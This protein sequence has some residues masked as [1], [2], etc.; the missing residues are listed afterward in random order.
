MAKD[1][2]TG[3]ILINEEVR[4]NYFLMRV[5]LPAI[6]PEPLPGNFVMVRIAGL[7]EPFLGRPL[8][9]YAFGRNKSSCSLEILY[10]VCGKGTQI[11]ARLIEGSQLEVHGPLGGSFPIFPEKK[12][13]V[14][15]AGGIG[16]APLSMLAQYLCKNTSF[17][18]S[19]MKFYLGAQSVDAMVGREKLGKLCYDINVCTD[20]GTL[21]QKAQVVAAFAGD[22]KKYK[23]ADTVIYACGPRGMLKALAGMLEGTEFI[24][25][26]SL[27]EKMACGTGACMG[28][29]VA[30][31]DAAGAPLYKRVCA[32]G[33][34][35]NLR[36]VIWENC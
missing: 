15:I 24:C 23:A 31:R 26:V 4:P 2:Y 9:I 33:P 21:G 6:F 13:I 27:E 14:F 3:T 1:V 12:N 34:V 17:K 30:I 7:S 18:R 28:C 22:Q 19:Q 5:A 29:A 16:V 35:F 8:S 32:D 20:D 11:L 36:D 10:R 25:F